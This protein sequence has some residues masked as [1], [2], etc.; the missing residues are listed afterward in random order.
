MS[1]SAEYSRLADLD[2]RAMAS[3]FASSSLSASVRCA[4][5]WTARFSADAAIPNKLKTKATHVFLDIVFPPFKVVGT[6][7]SR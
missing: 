4:A 3:S 6:D 5:D 2:L 1:S 7:A